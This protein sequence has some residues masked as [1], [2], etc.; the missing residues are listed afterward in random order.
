M[1]IITHYELIFT[2]IVQLDK[3]DEAN[4]RRE[5]EETKKF[6]EIEQKLKLAAVNREMLSKTKSA[7]KKR[8]LSLSPRV[9][10]TDKNA[11]ETKIDQANMRREI[12]LSKKVEKA[13]SNGS[14]SPKINK[15]LFASVSPMRKNSPG[16][17]SPRIKAARLEEFHV[18]ENQYC[19]CICWCT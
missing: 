3:V 15:A 5:Q 13:K 9:S 2:I 18:S 17:S 12:Y 19:P 14:S 7:S 11:I 16:D 4:K 1:Q 6:G 10:P 8:P